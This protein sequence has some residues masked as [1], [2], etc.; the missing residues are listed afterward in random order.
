MSHRHLSALDLCFSYDRDAAVLAQANLDIAPGSRVA[1][2]GANG[3]GKSTLLQCLAGTLTPQSGVIALDGRPMSWSRRGLRCHRQAVQLVFQDPDDQLFSADVA[4]D[5]AYGP[6]NLGLSG[7]EIRER[8]DRALKLLKI[9]DLR[10]RPTHQLSFGQRKRVAIAGAVAMQPCVLLLDEPTAG[11]DP[12][13]VDALFATLADLERAGTT[14]TMSTHD[15]ALALDWADSVAIVDRG[16]IRQGLPM[17]MLGDAGLIEAAQLRTP[18]LIRLTED[19]IADGVLPSDARPG[20]PSVLRAQLK[21]A[22]HAACRDAQAD[23]TTGRP[24]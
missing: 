19:L 3:S 5:V 11:V 1:L 12:A 10:A 18:W 14:V 9:D 23:A 13:G 4:E 21:S 17:R 24:G 6:V 15:T 22:Q 16:V 20:T 7:T 8:V 2:L